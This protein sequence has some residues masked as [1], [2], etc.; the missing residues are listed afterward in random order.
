MGARV[1]GEDIAKQIVDTFMET[2]FDDKHPN[3]PRR[4]DKITQ[5]E[6]L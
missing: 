1:I 4:I 3:H 5:I 2:E 6:K